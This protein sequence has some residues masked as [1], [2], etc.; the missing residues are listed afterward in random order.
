MVG[1]YEQYARPG[2]PTPEVV[3]SKLVDTPI[4]VALGSPPF[5]RVLNSDCSIPST[6]HH[7]LLRCL[8]HRFPAALSPAQALQMLTRAFWQPSL[9]HCWVSDLE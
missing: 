3:P 6:L 2:E 8:S 5:C 1:S 7:D 4:K 9:C